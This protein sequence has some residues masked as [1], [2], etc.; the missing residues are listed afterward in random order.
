MSLNQSKKI[1]KLK[2][3]KE[4]KKNKTKKNWFHNVLD[5]LFEHFISS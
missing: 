4:S 1:K 5:F 2:K 3:N